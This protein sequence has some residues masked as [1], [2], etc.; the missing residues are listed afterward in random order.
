MKILKKKTEIKDT[1]YHPEMHVRDANSRDI[2]KNNILA[3]Q[4][5]KNYTGIPIF[6]D[7]VPEDVE[8]VTGKFR[9]FLGIEYESDAVKKVYIRKKDGSLEKEVYV[10]SLIEHKRAVDYDVA[11]QLL[12]YMCAIWQEHKVAQNKIQEGVS[13]KKEFRYPL[14]IPIVYYEGK[15]KWTAGLH[16]KDRIEFADEMGKY[17]PDFTYQVVGVNEYTNEE[18]SEKQDEMSL[19]MMINKIQTQEDLNKFRKL[20]VVL[21]DSIYANAPEEIKEIYCTIIESLLKKMHMPS[22]EIEDIMGEMGGQSMG[23]LFE[24]MDKIDIQAEREKTKREKERA[25]AEKERADAEKKRADKLA[26]KL[27][28]MQEEIERLKKKQK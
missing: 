22:E 5:L 13:R 7:I 4:F 27:N 18:L 14:I 25:N 12:H 20:S 11:M 6:A 24:N 17:I 8:D 3:S 10:V 15:R 9:A 21:L 19:V 28:E 23:Y 2:F 1:S 16:L 26:E